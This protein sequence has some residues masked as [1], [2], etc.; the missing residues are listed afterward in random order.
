M[1]PLFALLC[2]CFVLFVLAVPIG[3][4]GS[5][6]IRSR[7]RHPDEEGLEPIWEGRSGGRIGWLNY[8]G[9]F[10]RLAVYEDF[11]VV[12]AFSLYRIDREDLVSVEVVR[13]FLM[14]RVKIESRTAPT[15]QFASTSPEW[16]RDTIRG[17][18]WD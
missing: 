11:I 5:I 3:I 10:I 9:P 15:V 17:E 12:G 13:F 16:L 2:P 4:L 1:E 18:E 6:F 8:K 7:R 14:Q